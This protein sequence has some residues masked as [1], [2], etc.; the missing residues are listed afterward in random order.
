[1]LQ[2]AKKYGI[3]VFIIGH[4]TKTG[5][6]AGPRVLEHIVDTVSPSWHTSYANNLFNKERLDKE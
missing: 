2:I 4:V 5:D 3:T 6:I 1:L